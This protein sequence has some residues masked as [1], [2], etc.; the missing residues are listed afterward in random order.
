MSAAPLVSVSMV[1]YNHKKY[2]GE[3]IRSVLGQTFGDLE[4]VIVNDGSTDGTASQIAAFDDPRIVAIHQDNRGPSA[5]TNR[6]LAACRGKYVALFSGDDV[7]RPDRLRRQV[8]EYAC[9][10][11]GVLFAGCDFIGEDG[12]PLS[13]DH[14]AARIFDP[15]DRRRAEVLARLF[16][17]GNYFNGITAFTEREIL[18]EA[19]YDVGLLQLQDFDVWSRLVKRYDLRIMPDWLIGYRIRGGSGNL[20]SPSPERLVRL[21]N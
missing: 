2:I 19:P 3:A 7:C 10:D 21:Q 18:L 20:S 11:R 16:H 13:G 17:H 5:A 12:H 6:A 14:F 9:G 1:T 4:L 8:A 15:T